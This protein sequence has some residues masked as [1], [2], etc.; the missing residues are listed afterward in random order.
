MN[1]S[2]VKLGFLKIIIYFNR[3]DQI[4]VPPDTSGGSQDLKRTTESLDMCP[5]SVMCGRMHE[6]AD[7]VNF[8]ACLDS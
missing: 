1:K 3:L 8:P 5:H 4:F 7:S 6:V 2:S